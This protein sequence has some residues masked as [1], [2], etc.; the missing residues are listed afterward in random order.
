QFPL[1]G[2]EFARIG[3]QQTADTFER[4]ARDEMRH[5]KYCRAIGRR[6]APSERA[7]DEA[8]ATYRAGG[9]RAFRGAGLARVAYA[10]DRGLVWHGGVAHG[11][12]S[13]LRARDPMTARA[14]A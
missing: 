14:A 12:A 8:G 1:I 2:R 10:I 7:W 3:D 11:I 5:T 9:G 13:F 6:Y 4:V